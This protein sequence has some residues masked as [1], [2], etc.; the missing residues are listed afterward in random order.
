MPDTMA[1]MGMFIILSL[2]AGTIDAAREVD[3]AYAET[4]VGNIKSIHSSIHVYI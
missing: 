2:T 3:S 1:S 4:I